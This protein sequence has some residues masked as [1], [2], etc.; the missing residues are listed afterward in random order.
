MSAPSRWAPPRERWGVG[1]T[2][3]PV[4]YQ[5]QNVQGLAPDAVQ[6]MEWY[7]RAA[8]AGDQDAL[9]AIRGAENCGTLIHSPQNT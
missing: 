2:Y 3:D 5:A 1:K 7:T 6:A 4:V 8:N 9:A